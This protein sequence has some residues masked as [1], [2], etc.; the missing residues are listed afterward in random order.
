[1]EKF[2]GGMGLPDLWSVSPQGDIA[3]V[4]GQEPRS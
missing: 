1:V 4:F 2:S 3:A